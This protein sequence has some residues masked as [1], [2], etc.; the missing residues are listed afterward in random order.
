LDLIKT[1]K[2]GA[3]KGALEGLQGKRHLSPGPLST[4]RNE[5]FAKWKNITSFGKWVWINTY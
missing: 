3:E 4:L 2:D 1:S 5:H